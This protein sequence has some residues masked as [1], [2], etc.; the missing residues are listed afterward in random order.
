M[1]N[2]LKKNDSQLFSKELNP[3]PF[4][5]TQVKMGPIG[6]HFKWGLQFLMVSHSSQ[7]PYWAKRPPIKSPPWN[8]SPW[9]R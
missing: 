5:I 6:S 7:Y 4:S 8:P 1:M 9:N 3:E 2:F